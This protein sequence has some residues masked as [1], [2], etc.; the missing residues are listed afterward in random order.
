MTETWSPSASGS[1]KVNFDTAIRDL[2]LVQAV[3]CR[4]ENGTIISSCF[5]YSPS[6][7]PSVGEAQAALLAASLASSLKLVNFVLDG[8][9]A[10]VINSLKDPSSVLN[11]K[12]DNLISLAL[13]LIPSSSLWEVRSHLGIGLQNTQGLVSRACT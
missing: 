4:N 2:F 5:Q 6:C 11:W 12:I 10:I 3:V 9:S 1:L 7:D 8:D 13:S